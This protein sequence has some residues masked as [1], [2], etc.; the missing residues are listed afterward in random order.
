MSENG[1]NMLK[2]FVSGAAISICLLLLDQY[3]KYL[4]ILHLKGK[5]AIPL[6]KGIFELQYLENR[7]AAFGSFQG[8]QILLLAVTFLALLLMIY[9][10]VKLPEQKRYMPL[11]ATVILLFSGAIGNMV[12]RIC[13][14]YVVDFLYVKVID[15]PIFN[16]ADCYLTIAAIALIILIMFV[17]Q[18]DELSFF[19]H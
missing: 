1:V 19:N 17:Y 4:A 3:T 6:I 10:Y 2:K 9:V 12:D 15:F 7:G 5:K 18:E 14:K 8:K 11:K 13:R 16:V